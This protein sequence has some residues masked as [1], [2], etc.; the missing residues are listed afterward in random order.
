MGQ[1]GRW[2]YLVARCRVTGSCRVTVHRIGHDSAEDEQTE[3]T[4]G[5]HGH[6]KPKQHERPQRAGNEAKSAAPAPRQYQD[7]RRHD[8][9]LPTAAPQPGEDAFRRHACRRD[10]QHDQRSFLACFPFCASTRCNSAI[11]S[12]VRS[13]WLTNCTSIGPGAP[14]NTRER[15]DR[16]SLRTHCSRAT[17]G[18]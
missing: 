15:N 18:R 14:P 3:A 13:A 17:A 6:Q 8:A 2:P 12:G 5:R 16:L 7:C 10:R 4:L 9:G 1:A 11:S